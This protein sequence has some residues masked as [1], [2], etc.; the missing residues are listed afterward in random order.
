MI[1][2]VH[3]IWLS[4]SLALPAV[5][6]LLSFLPIT[7]ARA[8]FGR[9]GFE[10]VRA[11]FP[12]GAVP[13][14]KSRFLVVSGFSPHPR[15]LR[16]R[17][18]G[19]V[20]R[21]FGGDGAVSVPNELVSGEPVAVTHEGKILILG[22]SR[23]RR[24][25]E[26]T[27]TLTRLLPSG[28]PD[29]GF[30]ENG[31]IKVDLGGKTDYASALFV[32]RKGR[33]VIGGSTSSTAAPSR[34]PNLGQLLLIRLRPGGAIDRTFGRGGHRV[35]SSGAEGS[36]I[37]IEEGLDGSLIAMDESDIF[38]VD[39]QGRIKRGFGV[40]GTV[41]L[42][43]LRQEL[44]IAFFGVGRSGIGVDSR[45]RILIAGTLQFSLNNED[46]EY[47]AAAL[48]LRPDGSID[49][50]YGHGGLA[51]ARI[52]DWT[53]AGS[54]LLDARSGRVVVAGS[55]Q[56]PR[57]ENSA[58]AAVAF[59]ARGNLDRSFGHRGMMRINASRSWINDTA[60]VPR[61]GRKAVLVGSATQR[62]GHHDDPRGLALARIRLFNG[63]RH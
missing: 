33:I 9:D 22:T 36:P 62:E 54:M 37:D 12:Q 44:G 57:G 20:D 16:I 26:L 60:I 56:L 59:D 49:R 31:T 29:R 17:N 63:L 21:S 48:R 55:S 15:I 4:A 3:G 5:L 28:K 27:A 45:G 24:V 50:S 11:G 42:L 7:P 2:R 40:R 52:G 35:L 10:I 6:V 19:S 58:F 43:S 38:A 13:S 23:S 14:G 18:D 61:P 25:G 41:N 46:L 30:G 51:R 32:D 53:F 34:G 8:A 1:R 39:E 47:R